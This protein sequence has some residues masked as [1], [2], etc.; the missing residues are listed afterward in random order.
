MPVKPSAFILALCASFWLAPATGGETAPQAP[1]AAPDAKTTIYPNIYQAPLFTPLFAKS[2][3][4]VR[5][6]ESGLRYYA[7]LHDVARAEAEIRRLKGLYPDWVVPTNIYSPSGQG[8]DEQ[9]FWD[10][11]ADNRLDE[12]RAGL[13]LRMKGDPTWKPSRDLTTK[14]EHKEASIRLVKFSDARDWTQVLEIADSTPGILHCAY[15]DIDWRVEEAFA[16]ISASTRAFE[17]FHAIIASCTDHGDRVATIRK[18]IG[19]FTTDQVKT[20]IAMGVKGSDGAGEF[21]EIRLDLTRARIGKINA[22]QTGDE[23]EPEALREL[24][25]ASEKS[26]AKD[27]LGLLGWFEFGRSHWAR[28]DKWFAL[29]LLQVQ[30]DGPS[31]DIKFVEGHAL[32]LV[33]QGQIDQA[34]DFAFDWRDASK[35]MRDIYIGAMATLL[36]RRDP[37]AI[38]A[39]AVLDDFVAIVKTDHSFAGAQALAWYHYDRRDWE[40]AIAWYEDGFAWRGIDPKLENSSAAKDEELI[41]AVEGYAQALKNRDRAAES[42]II[43]DAWRSNSHSMARLLIA[44][45]V[46]FLN[47][48]DQATALSHEIATHFE[49]VVR[50]ERSSFGAASLGWIRYRDNNFA[51]SV[52]WFEL[53]TNWSDKNVEDAKTFEGYSLALMAVGRHAQAEEI[54]WAWRAKSPD[55]RA[56]YIAAVVAQLSNSDASDKLSQARLDRFGF[57]VREDRSAAGAQALA[58]RQLGAGNCAYAA[59][60][61]RDALAWSQD[62][63]QAAKLNEGLAQ[64]LRATGQF[65]AAEDVAYQWRERSGAAR[66]LYIEIVVQEVASAAQG[67]GFISDDRLRGFSQIVLSERS[68]IG[69]QALGWARFVDAGCGF[70]GDWFRLATDWAPD[71]IGDEKA[72]EGMALSLAR[73][74]ALEKAQTVALA[75]K[76][77]SDAMARLYVETNVD[78]LSRDNPPEPMTEMRLGAFARQLEATH[79]ALGA[80][81]LGWYRRERQEMAEAEKWFKNAIDWWPAMQANLDQPLTAKPAR[82]QPVSAKLALTH[83]NYRRTPNAFA[84]LAAQVLGQASPAYVDMPEGKAMTVEGYALALRS[85]G[86]MEQAEALAHEW[87]N[88]WPG[89]RALYMEIAIAELARGPDSAISPQ[90]L[91]QFAAAINEDRSIAGA[92]AMGW[93]QYDRQQFAAAVDWF[94]SSVQWSADSSLIPDRKTLEAYILSL[95]GAGR[96]S[97]ATEAAGVWSDRL[98][99]L[100]TLFFETELVEMQSSGADMKITAER[101]QQLEATITE[102]QSFEGATAFGWFAYQNKDFPRALVWF[103]QA[104]VWAHESASA[105]KALEGYALTLRSL[106]QFAEFAEFAYQW[107]DASPE[108]GKLYRDGLVEFLTRADP[109]SDVPEASLQNFATLVEAERSVEGAQALGWYFNNHKTW[110]NAISWFKSSLDWAGIDLTKAG[111]GDEKYAKTAAKIVEGTIRALRNAGDASGAEEAAY[112]WRGR[113]EALRGLYVELFVEAMNQNDAAKNIT[114]DRLT[115]FQEFVAVDHSAIGAQNLGWLNYRAGDWAG[116]IGWFEKSI[117]WSPDHSGDAKSNEGYVLSLK[118]AQRYAEAEEVSWRWRNQSEKIRAA[119]ISVVAIQLTTENL[120]DAVDQPRI[121]RFIGVVNA[122]HS[123]EGAQALGWHR[124]AQDKCGFALPW[125]RAAAAWSPDHVGDAH[126]NEGLALALRAVGDYAGADDAAYAWSARAAEIRQLYIKIGVEEL[127]RDWPIIEIGEERLVRFA[128]IALADHSSSAA[129]ALGWRRY[130]QAGCGF[131]AHWFELASN[132]SSDQKGDMTINQGLGL[133]L[134]AIGRAGDAEA[135]VWR[136]ALKAPEMKKLYIDLGVE[137][138]SRDNPPEPMPETRI[139]RYEATIEPIKSALAAQALGWYRFQRHENGEALKWFKQALDWWPPIPIADAK[140]LAPPID[141]YSAILAKLALD[142][143]DYRRTPRAFPNTSLLIGKVTSTFV[144]TPEGLAKTVEGYARALHASG[145]VLEAEN[146]AWEWRDRWPPLRALFLDI[147][148]AE[149]ARENGDIVSADRLARYSQIIDGDHSA[150]GAVALGWRDYRAND[151]DKA[152][153]WFK[154]A[155]GWKPAGAAPD[156]ALIEAYALSLRGGKHLEAALSLVATWQD[157]A[158]ALA[159]LFIQMGLENLDALDASAPGAADKLKTLASHISKDKS[160]DGAAAFG[161]LAEKRND[162]ATALAWFKQAIIWSPAAGPDP[163]ALEGFALALKGL[164]KINDLLTFTYQW[165]ERLPALKPVFVD[166]VIDALANSA[167]DGV[168]L[169]SEVLVHASAI[170]AEEKS[171]NGAQALAWQRIGAKDWVTAAAWF[172]AALAWSPDSAD[173]AK[174][175]EGQAI[176]LRNL[177]RLD[178]AE[179][180]V[181]ARQ[182]Q[183]ENLRKLYIEIVSDRLTRK[184][185]SPPNEAGMARFSAIVLAQNSAN[186]A[187][188]LGWYSLNSR[189]PRAAAAW[190]EKSMAWEPSESNA[191]GLAYAYRQMRDRAAYAQVIN[192]YR[193]QYGKIADLAAGRAPRSA[194]FRAVAEPGGVDEPIDDAPAPLRSS[195]A[196]ERRA[197]SR[198]ANASG[199]GE[200]LRKKDYIGCLSLAQKRLDTG[201]LLASDQLI[202][203]WCLLGLSRGQEAAAAFDLSFQAATGHVRADAAYGK[204]LALLQS[205]QTLQAASAAGSA[206]LSLGRRNAIGSQVLGQRAVAAYQSG[207]YAEALELLN[208]RAAFTPETRDLMTIR[209]WSLQ[210]LGEREAA[211]QIFRNLDAQLSTTDTS[212][213]ISATSHGP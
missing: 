23:I 119:Y 156:A 107:R 108:L 126:L 25:A 209:A 68:T 99:V 50:L 123:V 159:P 4:E 32:A 212:D 44:L 118:G 87:R 56:N 43:A 169:T 39:Q 183:D 140:K 65:H 8:N 146:L 12:L 106:G 90:R 181:Y 175:I 31:E 75:W 101:S 79:S 30:K 13:A 161:W 120:R 164:G 2:N 163:K 82:Y 162:H 138:L 63:T 176:A 72:N 48:P 187:Q 184:P 155:L 130:L 29:A 153:D 142:H 203:G 141:A 201:S 143:A 196:R 167:T 102:A 125:F 42:I 20:L 193:D 33:K 21:D 165:S 144:D 73:T 121:E 171:V 116:A 194:E 111:S 17:I 114:A 188:A 28:A 98:P 189:Q 81:A 200:A 61:F 96:Y 64:S 24:E 11:F 77:R 139:A 6:D 5:V 10:L 115:R 154:T 152:A 34:R 84:S 208:R 69:A 191:L 145:R 150:L 58:W 129:Q 1:S 110:A 7:S 160:A 46:D 135:A 186:G 134:L 179:A 149:L 117:A 122:D 88:R 131:G 16:K 207:R 177:G 3:K 185:P 41:K 27:D 85:L 166:A 15:M 168:E 180:L 97:E 54:A 128:N 172:K 147:A 178:E 109:V 86:H 45:A 59:P 80:Q 148:V 199:M 89:L 19:V 62:A 103:K 74:G 78:A 66:Q 173:A 91:D 105:P 157:K 112:A 55:L 35:T 70:G 57:L 205:G 95:R 18:A 174:M 100:R 53:A 40:T 60:W 92:A 195:P 47:S 113:D 22:G 158:P 49:E 67:L 151:F 36:T 190:F 94:K 9:P 127:T 104:M 206:N 132:W 182:A 14:I 202:R 204:A 124:L 137:Q 213:A 51:A 170:F 26:R 198:A 52:D 192:S 197:V 71:H 38:L 83:E 76:D 133:S 211:S 93:N 136:W 210:N 37:P